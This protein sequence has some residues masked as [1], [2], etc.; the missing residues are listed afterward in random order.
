MAAVLAL[1][2]VLPRFRTRLILMMRKVWSK[3]VGPLH[4]D[5]ISARKQSLRADELHPFSRRAERREAEVPRE[6]REYMYGYCIS[7]D[8]RVHMWNPLSR[9]AC[10]CKSNL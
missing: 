6:K 9:I 5:K 1:A 7:I 8:M 10:M 2:E 3:A 4:V